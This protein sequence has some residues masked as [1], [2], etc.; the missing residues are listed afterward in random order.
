MALANEEAMIEFALLVTEFTQLE[1][2][3]ERFAARVLGTDDETAA[4]VMRSI[5]S[6][7]AKI[8]LLEATLERSRRNQGKPGEFDL[9]ID[10]F[11]ALNKIRNDYVHARYMTND[12]TGEVSW[13]RPKA[14]PL[15][16]DHSAYEPFDITKL[17][18]A[19]KRMVELIMQISLVVAR[20][21]AEEVEPEPTPRP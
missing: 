5:V 10:E 4:H 7:K 12:M 8:D 3:M 6:A 13:V 17:K 15:L 20:D 2:F 14:D 19:R 1:Y 18:A 21:L 11:A 16:L 9:V